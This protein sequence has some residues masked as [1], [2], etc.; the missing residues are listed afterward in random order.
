MSK[1]LIT[2]IIQGAACALYIAIIVA[3][4][5]KIYFNRRTQ[6]RIDK[7]FLTISEKIER[8]NYLKTQ[9]HAISV[10]KNTQRSTG[11][12]SLFTYNIQSLSS[13]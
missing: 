4:A 6:K 3:I 7:D 8:L 13:V 10:I 5:Y 12:F 2:E 1:T 11:K 9:L